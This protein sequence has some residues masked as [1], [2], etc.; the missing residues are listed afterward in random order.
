MNTRLPVT[1]GPALHRADTAPPRIVR[2]SLL[3]LEAM[4]AVTSIAGGAALIVGSLF[5]E[6]AT[7]LSPPTA[8]LDGSPFSGYL[9]PGLLLAVIVGGTQV[10]AFLLELTR[11]DSH[12]PAAAV[13]AVALLIWVFVQMVFIPFSFLQAIYFAVGIAETGLIMLALGILRDPRMSR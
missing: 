2:Y 6:L 7:I 1:S 11:N 10:V 4:V 12:L 9:V 3:V 8:Y 5:P 13:A